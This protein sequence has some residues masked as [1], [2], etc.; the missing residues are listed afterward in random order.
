MSTKSLHV[1]FARMNPPTVAHIE[2][3]SRMVKASD[4]NFRVFLSLTHDITNPLTYDERVRVIVDQ[5]PSL[6]AHIEGARDL[7]TAMDQVDQYMTEHGYTNIIL[8]GGTDRIPALKRV[9]LYPERWKFKV[10]DII[11]M[12]RPEGSVSAS[13]VRLAAVNRDTNA[14]TDMAAVSY[15]LRPWLF[16]TLHERLTDGSLESKTK[17]TKRRDSGQKRANAKRLAGRI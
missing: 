3:I 1:T 5:Y 6:A 14:F 10:Q 15:E 11:E 17:T 12:E 16:E 8:W 4:K 13:A 2:M 9:L 7:F